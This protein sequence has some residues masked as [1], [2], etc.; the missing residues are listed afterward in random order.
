[1]YDSA[2]NVSSVNSSMLLV[3]SDFNL[4]STWRLVDIV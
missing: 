3:C 1:M 4:D 2:Y